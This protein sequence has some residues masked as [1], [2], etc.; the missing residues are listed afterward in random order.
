MKRILTSALLAAGIILSA[1]A[2][3]TVDGTSA[4]AS[5]AI[6]ATYD[7]LLRENFRDYEVLF[8]RADELARHNDFLRALD[9]LD[10]AMKYCPATDTE[11][12]FQITGLR[13]I[14]YYQLHRYQQAL[15]A[16][17]NALAIDS[18]H[19]PTVLLKA[20]VEYE[21]GSFAAAKADY[22]RLQRMNP[23]SADALY[24]LARIAAK[25]NNR[26]LAN[27]YMTQALEF[28]TDKSMTLVQRAHVH[29]MLDEYNAAVED[30]LAAINTD[31][32]NTEAIIEFVNMA[33][34]NYTAVIDG[35]SATIQKVPNNPL[36]YYM[37]ATV[38]ENHYHYTDAIAD[39]QYM[40]DNK[41]YKYPGLYASLA[42]CYYALG[43]YD[44][45]M[46]NI[47]IA[48]GQAGDN[49]DELALY[50]TV[51]AKIQRA[52]GENEK[53]LTSINNALSYDSELTP[54]MVE[55]AL[56]LTSLKQPSEA[57]NVL[58]EVIMNEPLDAEAYLLR[59]WV[60]N[61]FMNQSKA[62][63][64][65]YTRV[66]DLEVHNQEAVTS[67]LG[68]AQLFSG[69]TAR[70][71]AWM[72]ACLEQPDHDGMIHYYGACFYAWANRL[73]RAFECMQKALEAGY[74]NYYDWTAN[75][76]GRIN[77]EP[78]RD[79]PRFRALLDEHKALFQVK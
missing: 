42:K 34:S 75:C 19:Y 37:R 32:S 27:E 12:M 59:A 6:M 77:V 21:L 24:G 41:L 71:V 57:S 26:G 33:G 7:E 14:C 61:D 2:R 5:R 49:P 76:D 29:Q 78:L 28:T 72:D 18:T 79:D 47:A 39:Y 50:F 54:A 65:Y 35:I 68:F 67:L 36:Y 38:A 31:A 70:A 3:V 66:I 43:F 16:V 30:L 15:D 74:A 73:D 45:A 46:T 10:K 4:E 40:L 9:D 52:L 44:D 17:N 23:H 62:A 20:N 53:A 1:Q 11:M 63:A 55:K 51:Q 13:A 60:L 64:G 22:G 58:G 48:L 8:R 56:V 69:Q 25:E